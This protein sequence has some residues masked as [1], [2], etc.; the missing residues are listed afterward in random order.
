MT[1]SKTDK[2]IYELKNGQFVKLSEPKAPNKAHFVIMWIGGAWS[3][4]QTLRQCERQFPILQHKRDGYV[5]V[6]K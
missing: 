1:K 4:V 6:E 3:P 2:V 5:V